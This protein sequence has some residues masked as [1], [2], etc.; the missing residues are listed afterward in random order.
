MEN[1]LLE[2]VTLRGE[3]TK[4]YNPEGI[5]KSIS[6]HSIST[7]KQITIPVLN[8]LVV[9]RTNKGKERKPVQAKAFG[10]EKTPKKGTIAKEKAYFLGV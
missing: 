6:L 7:P 10:K 8:D 5:S 2:G 3:G 1:K 9:Q 4:G